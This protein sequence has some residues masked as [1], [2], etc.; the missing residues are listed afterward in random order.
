MK[1]TVLDDEHESA[2]VDRSFDVVYVNCSDD[3]G[4]EQSRKIDGYTDQCI[5]SHWNSVLSSTSFPS[6]M[7]C[8]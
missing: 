8:T 6:I 1:G 4:E 7:P 5:S 3:V 2:F